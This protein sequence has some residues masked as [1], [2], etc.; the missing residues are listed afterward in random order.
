MGKTKGANLLLALAMTIVSVFSCFFALLSLKNDNKVT[1]SAAT[2]EYMDL[3]GIEN[4]DW[5]AH[6]GEYYFGGVTL[7]PFGYFNTDDSICGAWY[8]GNNAIIT[9]NN[10][11][12]I[13]QYIY[14]N[15]VQARK[16]VTDNA[17]GSK[18]TNAC[19]CW[20]SNPAAYPIYVETTGDSGIIIKIVKAWAGDKYTLT[21]KAGFSLI[22]NDGEII[23]LSEDV[24]YNCVGNVPTRAEQYT[25]SFKNEN[26]EVIESKRYENGATLGQLPALPVKEDLEGV[27]QIDGV[28]ITPETVYHYNTDKTA[29]AVYTPFAVEETPRQLNISDLYN[30]DLI[31]TDD[32]KDGQ[33]QAT[34]TGEHHFGYNAANSF[35]LEFDMQYNKEH[36]EF[37]AFEVKMVRAGAEAS[38][39]SSQF[40]LGWHIYFCRPGNVSAITN[41]RPN[42]ENVEDHRI[43]MS[44][45]KTGAVLWE[46]GAPTLVGGKIY[47]VKLGYKVVDA[48]TGTVEMYTYLAGYEVTATYVLG[49]EY[50]ATASE[51]DRLL[52]YVEGGNAVLKFSDVGYMDAPSYDV[53]FES[54]GV[55]KVENGRHF[56]LPEEMEEG[57]TFVGWTTDANF[58]PGVSKLYPAGYDMPASN[59]LKLHAVWIDFALQNGAAVKTGNGS[60]IRF[61]ADIR[62]ESYTAWQ[63]SG[64]I[65]GAGILIVPTSYLE[66]LPFVHSSFPAGYYNDVPH[67]EWFKQEGDTWTYS[68]A[69]VN[70]PTGLYARSLSAKGYLKIAYS[71]GT[72]GY[73]YTYY[74][75][76]NNARS[77]YQ[78]ATM[79]YDEYKD[80][81]VAYVN[82]VADIQLDENFTATLSDVA[83]KI[84]EY[85]VSSERKDATVTVSL[86]KSASAQTNA[87]IA[88]GTALINGVRIISGYSAIIE[89]DGLYWEV[90]N[91]AVIRGEELIF[92]LAPSNAGASKNSDEFVFYNSSDEE[93]NF[94]L[95]DFTKRH[96]GYTENGVNQKVNS[97]MAGVNSQ[98]FFSQEWNSLAFYWYDTVGSNDGY[99]ED[100]ASG[101]RTFLAS[102]PVDDYGYVWQSNDNVLA[103]DSTPGT[104]H[105]MGWPFPN[106]K[107]VRTPSWE[108]N[109]S[110]QSWTSEG[111]SATST[112]NLYLG[113][114]NA[115][116]GSIQFTSNSLSN[117][118]RFATYY[119]PLL[120]IDIRIEDATNVEEIYVWYQTT[121]SKSW[122]TDKRVAVSE[123][124]FISYPYEGKYE[125]LLFLPMYA[126][127]A[128]GASTSTKVQQIRIE[129][130]IK[131]GKTLSGYVG[132]NSVRPTFDTR[133]S[134]NNSI[135]ISSL[136]QDYDYTGDLDFLAANITRARKAMNFLM[137]MYDSARGLNRQSYLVGHDGDKENL[138]FGYATDASI[139]GSL[140]NGYWDISFMPAYDFQSNMYFYKALADMAHLEKVLEEK[141]IVVDKSAAKVKTADREYNHGESAY[142][143][144]SESL[145]AIAETVKAAMQ[146][147][148]VSKDAGGFWNPNTGRFIAGYD[149]DGKQYDYGY[150]AWNLEAIYYGIATDEQAKAIMAWL[151]SE[152]D[153][154]KYDFAPVSNTVQGDS[155]ILNGEYEAQGDNWLNCQYG[156]AIMYTSFYDLMARITVLG[157]DNA[158]D[159]LTAIMAWYMEIYNAYVA[160]GST[161]DDFYWDYY[162]GVKYSGQ[163]ALQNGMKGTEERGGETA[164]VLGID[165]EFL[166]SYLLISAVPYGF[167][168]VEALD[169]NTLQ[170][171]TALPS[172]LD[173]FTLENLAFNNVKYDLTIFDNCFQ[174]TAVRGKV[175]GQKIQAVLDVSD[176]ANYKVYVNGVERKDY[177]VKDGKV[178]VTLDFGAA[179]VEVR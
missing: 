28:T 135:L 161:P 36:N 17:T 15:G 99:L 18:L 72:T 86:A 157:A 95:N 179:I 115:V 141:G 97:T 125:H 11:C 80:M 108:F 47:T 23:Y 73:V 129:I 9:A 63:N 75:E 61:L 128:W 24:T 34:S 92:T 114:A 62:A 155:S 93:L 153:L 41:I 71:D 12:D 52:F 164:G 55:E 170:I 138:V 7:S 103:N 42:F 116:S 45:S 54:N 1:A 30:A 8:H 68:A 119:A 44:D 64:V 111:V 83:A 78:V 67:E 49:A 166:E 146:V 48:A 59:G 27:W 136:R 81:V 19:N 79:A 90:K 14:V 6:E 85:T 43:F 74:D 147:D 154:Y 96:S 40:Y 21:F 101:L 149:A 51:F 13:M 124:A 82:G 176:K 98:E 137:Q 142:T 169:G 29:V 132:L 117:S 106:N 127:P 145:N 57:K 46:T 70:I 10:G 123:K 173:Y 163:H 118:K 32:F 126:E 53:T 16:A 31:D 140:S 5:G 121:S 168:G 112:N 100:R 150:V 87:S 25:L 110:S 4:R 143:Y 151:E 69:L 89:I 139:A 58:V 50:V 102:V 2:I 158:Y 167:F 144:T 77:M 156:G 134:N 178:Y 56:I 37:S 76:T 113:T 159:R 172:D 88:L 131:E 120:E 33:V 107:T 105:R 66:S 104:E 174:I 171:A 165:G 160:S 39:I 22:R 84:N 122:T 26:G 20:L 109:G 175:D 94:F 133:H 152:D 162:D 91:N 3:L 177:T 35:M 60:G 148:A 65:V 130:K 38:G